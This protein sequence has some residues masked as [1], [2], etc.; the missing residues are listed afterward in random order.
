MSYQLHQT[1]PPR[2]YKASATEINDIRQRSLFNF[3]SSWKPYQTRINPVRIMPEMYN[4]RTYTHYNMAFNGENGV[5]PKI[6]S[7]SGCFNTIPVNYGMGQY[8]YMNHAMGEFP[9]KLF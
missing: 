4:K 2:S 8:S 6:R 3:Q 7:A 9:G 5:E 1:I